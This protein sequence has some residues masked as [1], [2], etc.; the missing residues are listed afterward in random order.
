MSGW[1]AGQDFT[2]YLGN[3]SL[4]GSGFDDSAGDATHGYAKGDVFIPVG[5]HDIVSDTDPAI[6][7]IGAGS[8]KK[9]LVASTTHNVLIN[10]PSAY[11]RTYVAPAGRTANPHGI[12]VRALKL[13]YRVNTNNLTSISLKVYTLSLAAAAA[14]PSATEQTST[15]AGATVT[16][17]ANQYLATATVTTPTFV[18]TADNEFVGE[19]V[20]VTPAMCTCDILG[21]VWHVSVALY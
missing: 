1:V 20:I 17:A 18:T 2:N 11:L 14:V 4:G 13:A 6:T 5:L 3:L 15:T 21:A 8:Y 9:T 12:K 19:A 7:R 10:L 16:A